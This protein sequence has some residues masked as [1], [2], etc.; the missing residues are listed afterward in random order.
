MELSGATLVLISLISVV[1]L[2]SLISRKLAPSSMKR[3]PPGPWCLPVIGNLHQILTSK[4]PVVLRDLAKKHGPVMYLRLGQVDAIVISS[5]WA[6]EEVLREKDL[7]MASRPTLMISEIMLYRNLDIAFAPYGA[8]WR[9]LQK[10]CTVELLSE[11]K[12]RQFSPVRDNETMSLVRNVR[13]AMQP[14]KPLNLAKLLISCSNSITGKTS[15]G[16]MC[17]SELQEQFLTAMDVGLKL[18][19]GLCVGDLFPSLWFVDVVTGLRGQLW[20]ARRQLDK[21]LDKIIS[22]SE[23]R[24]GDHL[25]SVLLRIRDE[26]GLDLPMG[27]DNVK[28]II[29]DMFTAGTETTSSA[30]EWVMSELMRNPD[31]M[32]KAQAEVRRTF[33]NKSPQDHEGHV[34]ELHYTKMVIKESMRLNP[35]VPLLVPRVCRETCD[36]GGFEVMEGTRVMVNTWALGRN[37]EYWHEPEEFRPERFEDGTATYKGSRL[38]YLPFGSGRRNCPG[39][40][41]G[42]AVLELMV[43]RLL[44]YFDWSLPVGVKP[45]ELDME[46]EVAATS[47]RKNQLH[48]VATPYKA[49]VVN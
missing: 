28:A 25:P 27:L 18:S 22:Q 10:I 30:S 20:S 24:R 32:T 41:F 49:C 46:M 14:D 6:A 43:A 21:V 26:G 13:D 15:F 12:V 17:S 1:I 36:I 35:V 23:M 34:A 2:V 38:D 19:A 3:Q 48:L 7:S 39:D 5:R 29:M 31:V 11:R 9:T 37:P 8:Y 4:L 45:S 33:D 44:Y 42:M 47:K 16:E 40:T